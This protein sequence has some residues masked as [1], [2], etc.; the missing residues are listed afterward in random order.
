MSTA[1]SGAPRSAA[2]AHADCDSVVKS[3][4]RVLRILEFFDQR[5]GAAKAN[6]VSRALGYPH[7]STS[8]LLRSL[9]AAG[10]LHYDRHKRLYVPTLRVAMLGACWVAP[11]LAGEGL[12]PRLVGAL[13]ER[14]RANALLAARNGDRVEV[15]Y[16]AM[17]TNAAGLASP[18]PLTEPGLGHVALSAMPE[19]EV[20]GLVHRLNAAAMD[21]GRPL[22]RMG[23]LMSALTRIREDG[24]GEACYDD[25]GVIAAALPVRERGGPYAVA[26]TLPVGDYAS[27]RAELADLLHDELRRHFGSPRP[28]LHW[29]TAERD[30]ALPPTMRPIPRAALDRHHHAI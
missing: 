1:P 3:A 14:A 28:I 10:Y 16:S 26:I 22:T 5:R 20:R 8:A 15:V 21:L 4:S 9:V 17:R 18:R 19:C 11:K 6:T 25:T 23:E 29:P 12:L 24:H 7:S 13:A 30:A 2:T 27:R